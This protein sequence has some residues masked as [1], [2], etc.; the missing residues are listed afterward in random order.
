MYVLPLD[1]HTVSTS[2]QD[3]LIVSITKVN[4]GKYGAGLNAEASRLSNITGHY[5][6]Y[7]QASER[8][9]T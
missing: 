7:M 3:T 9:T 5:Y 4:G 1:Y 6:N 8:T 2:G